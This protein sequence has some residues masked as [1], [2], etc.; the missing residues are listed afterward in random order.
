MVVYFSATGNSRYCAQMLADRLGDSLT[1]AFHFIRDGIRPELTST[2]PWV[3]VAPTY[4]W[5]MPR[6]FQEFI[7]NGGFSGS[8]EAY[9]VITCG[10]EAG[11]ADKSL[12]AICEEKGMAYR[13]K[14]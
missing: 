2:S 12:K 6:L 3:F 11:A 8:R 10:G 5:Q 1:D 9:F 4:S 14:W 13:G 7:R